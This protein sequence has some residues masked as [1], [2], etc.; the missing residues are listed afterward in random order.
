[1]G[2][3]LELSVGVMLIVLGLMNLSGVLPPVARLDRRLGRLGGYQTVRSLIVG[4]V[5]GLAGSAAVALL[6]L[7]AIGSTVWSV[8]YLVVFGVG[9]V[10]GM[11]L[12]TAGMAWPLVYAGSR[13]TWLPHRMRIASGLLSLAVG[14]AIAY[15]IAVI[16]GLFTTDPSWTPQ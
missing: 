11:M 9:T 3:S 4:M 13:F 5:H 2:L 12:I 6:V 7:A 15:Q 16:D 1:V 10:A 8:L 14:L